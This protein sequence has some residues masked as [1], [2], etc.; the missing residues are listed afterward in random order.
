MER[1]YENRIQ[2]CIELRT[3]ND[4][5]L[6]QLAK[7]EQASQGLRDERDALRSAADAA[8]AQIAGA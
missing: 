4:T 1:E 7:A 5:L 3:E 8:A 2:R 6:A